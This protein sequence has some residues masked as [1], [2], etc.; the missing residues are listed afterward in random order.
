MSDSF[1]STTPYSEHQQ[2]DIHELERL[3]QRVAELEQVVT[4]Q[5]QIQQ[6]AI[7]NLCVID[8]LY[9]AVLVLDLN[10][11]I[12]RW[13]R[14][15][16]VLLGYQSSEIVGKHVMMLYASPS[17]DQ[18]LPQILGT[19]QHHK[20]YVSDALWRC[21][22]GEERPVQ[23]TMALLFDV[24]H[25]TVGITVCAV[26]RP[27]PQPTSLQWHAFQ[28]LAEHAPDGIAMINLDGIITYTNPSM[29]AMLKATDAIIGQS[30][31]DFYAEGK[32][33]EPV[34]KMV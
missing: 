14:G 9:A 7:E 17:A 25:R 5:Q 8:Q 21:Q 26:D 24:D 29:K 2:H 1:N 22:S 32:S 28:T 34:S 19:V 13:S 6:G 11:V 23:L 20:T 12:I 33:Y 15:A 10:G 16:T 30:A 31:F 4:A 18:Y 3:R 27:Y